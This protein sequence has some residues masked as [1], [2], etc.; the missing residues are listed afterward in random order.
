MGSSAIDMIVLTALTLP[1]VAPMLSSGDRSTASLSGNEVKVATVV[2]IVLQVSYFTG[3]HA[4]R[5]STIGKMALRT[6]L[7]R[8]DGSSVTPAVAFVRAV[9][10]VGINFISGLL[11][12]PAVVNELRPLWHPRRQTFH[13]QLAK[14][15]VVINSRA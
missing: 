7:V 9:S 14:T 11:I 13:D 1:F 3:M 8:D 2:S 12:A 6:V 5:G 15:V 10:L 4:W